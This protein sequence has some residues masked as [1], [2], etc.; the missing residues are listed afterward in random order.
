M[1]WYFLQVIRVGCIT[2][3]KKKSLL[4]QKDEEESREQ[5]VGKKENKSLFHN[6]RWGCF[7]YVDVDLEDST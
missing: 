5:Y 4:G 2:Q 6:K 3:H 7:G 1:L